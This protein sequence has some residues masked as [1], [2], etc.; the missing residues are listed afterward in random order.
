MCPID[1]RLVDLRILTPVERKWLNDYHKLVAKK[2][3]PFMDKSELAWLKNACAP[4]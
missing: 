1:T 3:A 2:L 4:V